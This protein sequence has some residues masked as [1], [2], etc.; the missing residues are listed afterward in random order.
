MNLFNLKWFSMDSVRVKECFSDQ[1]V[2]WTSGRG[3]RSHPGHAAGLPPFCPD[4]PRG[5]RDL[6]NKQRTH[7]HIWPTFTPNLNKQTQRTF[8]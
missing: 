3:R 5:R 7:S 8:S 6:L 4:T 2:E 1:R